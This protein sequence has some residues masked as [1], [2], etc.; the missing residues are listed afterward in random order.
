MNKFKN[1]L[2]NKIFLT[3]FLSGFVFLIVFLLRNT[4]EVY[5]KWIA[6]SAIELK[7]SLKFSDN[8]KIR[9][10]NEGFS[11]P[12]DIIMVNIDDKTTNKLW[13]FPFS[14]DKYIDVIKNLNNKW[15]A[16]IWLDIIFWEKKSDIPYDL[17]IDNNLSKVF[18]D[19][20]NI[21]IW[22]D[23]VWKKLYIPPY[24]LFAKNVYAHWYFNPNISEKTWEV[25]SFYPSKK[26]HI[27][28]KKI[29]H[30]WSI[31]Q[32]NKKYPVNHFSIEILK[33]FY[34]AKDIIK[35]NLWINIWKLKF[36]PFSKLW[37]DEVLINF[38]RNDNKFTKISFSDVYHKEWQFNKINFKNKII[39]IWAT[40]SW[41][42]DIF[43]SPYWRKFWVYSHAN[44]INTIINSNYIIYF[45][46]K[47][48][49][50]L[51]LLLIITAIYFNFSSNNKKLLF[52]N[53]FIF[54]IFIFL[55]YWIIIFG[56][57]FNNKTIL[58]LNYSASIVLAFILSITF[59]NIAKYLIENKDKKKVLKA[60]WEYISK[61]VAEEILSG[62]GE[63]N[64]KWE[65]KKI[66]T[67]FSDIEWFTSI[68][69]KLNPEEL[70]EF[71]KEYLWAMS[72][73][74]MDERWMIDKF[75]WDAIMAL[76]W[77]FWK[78]E[79]SS[80]RA[81][82]ASLKQQQLLKV[83]NKEW[84][85]RFWEELKIRMWI[86]TWEA[87]VWN[88][89]AIGRK[90]EFTALWDSVNLASRL[91]EINKKYWT[92]LCVSENI[93]EEQKQNFDFRYLD[94]IRVK[95]KEIPVSIYELLSEKWKLSDLKK[96][97]VKSFSIWINLY[98][99]KEFKKASE[100]FNKLYLM[101]DKP[102][103]TYAKRCLQFEINP[104]E[105]NWD[106]VWTMNTK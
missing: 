71:L 34:W 70:V 3:I 73:I 88:I 80:F 19:A 74:I 96:D 31:F 40:A 86:N 39:L 57:Y 38:L 6:Y 79:D 76:W 55:P 61:D 98:L 33:K 52:S 104:P 72:N 1:I 60:L 8:N 17:K 26:L 15:A 92:Y 28:N 12:T 67:F 106:W 89:W 97:I 66:T 42:K 45:N 93:F 7:N 48:E 44:I 37:N 20:W 59:S 58:L 27:K 82:K 2:K 69:E 83:L 103:L 36:V 64:L 78:E 65:R 18:K 81:C 49:L 25:Y 41:I 90:M 99:K 95:W 84:K 46:S 32:N 102:S 10:F 9:Y 100:I 101:W 13:L 5:N 11:N 47:L 75:E 56:G 94:R 4:F 68:S 54:T 105:E 24:Y 62:A 50:L 29:L 51:I 16:V 91:E 22:W 85:K 53:I 35:T 23:K 21:V 87:I 77:V 63:V 30:N 14:R 43:E